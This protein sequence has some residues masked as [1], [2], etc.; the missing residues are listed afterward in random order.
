MLQ[1]YCFFFTYATFWIYF[2]VA[3]GMYNVL[4]IVFLLKNA[5]KMKKYLC[6]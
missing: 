5:E 3:T 6:I 1:K 2:V 4:K